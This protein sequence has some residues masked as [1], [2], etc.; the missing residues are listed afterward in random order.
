[1]MQEAECHLF[2]FQHWYPPPAFLL[3]TQRVASLHFL[4]WEKTPL[5]GLFLEVLIPL[6]C[7]CARQEHSTPERA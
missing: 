3:K 6:L 4:F 7:W 2:A 5:N 1:M